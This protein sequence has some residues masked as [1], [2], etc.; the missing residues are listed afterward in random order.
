MAP[1]NAEVARLHLQVIENLL[2]G[3]D[4][5]NAWQG[6]RTPPPLR[7]TSGLVIHHDWPTDPVYLLFREIFL[8]EC[9]TGSGFYRPRADHTII[10]IGANIGMFALYVSSI[11]PGA[12]IYAFEPSASTFQRLHQNIA[13]NSME[14]R[15]SAFPFAVWRNECDQLLL[16]YKCSGRRSFFDDTR[17]W[18]KDPPELVKCITLGAILE[19]CTEQRIDLLKIDAEGSEVEI[20]GSC[21][22]LA[23]DR[24]ERVTLEYHEELRPGS[25]QAILEIL[26]RLGFDSVMNCCSTGSGDSIGIIQASRRR[27][28]P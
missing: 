12:R 14:S 16:N 9:Y 5:W 2:N 3:D 23:W 27:A 21:D 18:E 10:D 11:A 19:L 13:S 25:K 1:A 4:V 20:L 22:D 24:I 17:E 15:V 28:V 26:S 6:R 7:T 8:G